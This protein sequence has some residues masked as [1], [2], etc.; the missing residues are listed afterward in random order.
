M[1]SHTEIQ[2]AQL[3]QKPDGALYPNCNKPLLA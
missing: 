1:K 3:E 2:T